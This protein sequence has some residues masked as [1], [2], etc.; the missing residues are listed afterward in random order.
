ME[1]SNILYLV[2]QGVRPWEQEGRESP[3]DLTL[4]L[5]ASRPDHLTALADRLID[6]LFAASAELLMWTTRGSPFTGNRLQEKRY[7]ARLARRQPGFGE[8]Y[9]GTAPDYDIP[10]TCC[11]MMRPLSPD[12]YECLVNGRYT[13]A[14]VTEDSQLSEDGLCRLA[15]PYLA[16]VDTDA[17]LQLLATLPCSCL[18]RACDGGGDTYS[19]IQIIGPVPILCR[20]LP[21]LATNATEA[22]GRDDICMAMN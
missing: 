8:P 7:Q 16:G 5:V 12:H 6:A 3:S 21:S 9:V 14:V 17:L 22:G 10:C 2:E 18:L 15:R 20:V 19:V 1:H 13:V 11:R 4:T